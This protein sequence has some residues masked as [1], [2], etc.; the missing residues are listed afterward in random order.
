M[1][2]KLALALAITAAATGAKANNLDF[3]IRTMALVT[4]GVEVCGYELSTDGDAF[5]QLAQADIKA[6]PVLFNAIAD[7]VATILMV[8]KKDKAFACAAVHKGAARFFK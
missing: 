7:R 3:E 5:R 2:K 1:L 4:V 8:V 6:N